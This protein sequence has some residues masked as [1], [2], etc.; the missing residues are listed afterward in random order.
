MKH[1]FNEALSLVLKH[2]GGYVNHPADPGGATNRGVTQHTYDTWR[3][4]MGLAVRTV[5][6]ITDAEVAAIYRRDYWNAV[7]GDE[8]P[9]GLDYAV[10]DFAVN[11]GPRRARQFLQRVLGVEDDGVFGPVTMAAIGLADPSRT[12]VRLC[13]NRLAWLKRLPTWPTFGRGWGRRVNEVSDVAQE[14]AAREPDTEP[15]M[16][17]PVPEQE[18]PIPDDP[19]IPESDIDPDM[20]RDPWW[21][22]L[23]GA[24]GGLALLALLAIIFF[25]LLKG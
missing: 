24:A 15:D 23:L 20:E 16:P 10:F 11:S 8:L 22:R 6:K 1:L 13:Q 5:R 7:R 9:A 25:D 4:R 14:M 3:R 18:P 2:E 17:S 12:A 19:G 21:R